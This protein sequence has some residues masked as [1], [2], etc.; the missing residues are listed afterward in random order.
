MH[1]VPKM[2]A[3]PDSFYQTDHSIGYNDDL[4]ESQLSVP[5][6]QWNSTLNAKPGI[7]TDFSY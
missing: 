1:P 7:G 6:P 2:L 5:A 4:P 3:M